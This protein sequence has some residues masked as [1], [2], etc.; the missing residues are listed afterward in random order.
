MHKLRDALEQPEQRDYLLSMQSFSLDMFVRQ[1][2]GLPSDRVYI[3][4]PASEGKETVVGAT[5]I[6]IG[7]DTESGPKTLDTLREHFRGFK[8]AA[9]RGRPPLD[10]LSHRHRQAAHNLSLTVVLD[11]GERSHTKRSCRASR[12]RR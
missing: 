12:E 8:L 7:G 3:V 1:I 11:K 4:R 10:F 5:I 2:E 9:P 6:N